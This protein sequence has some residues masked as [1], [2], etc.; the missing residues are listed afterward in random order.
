MPLIRK[1]AILELA[2]VAA[3]CLASAHASDLESPRALTGLQLQTL[4]SGNTVIGADKDGPFWMYYANDTTVWGRS[5]GGDV[6]I[7]RWWIENHSYCRSWRR[8]FNGETR[9]WQLSAVGEDILVW[10][11]L[12]GEPVGQST[13]RRG[14]AIGDLPDAGSQPGQLADAGSGLSSAL[15]ALVARAEVEPLGLGAPRG[16]LGD[17]SDQ[18]NTEPASSPTKPAR[19]GRVQDPGAPVPPVIT[20]ISSSADTQSSATGSAAGGGTRVG[21]FLDRLGVRSGGAAAEGG[22]GGSSGGGREAKGGTD[23]N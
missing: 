9:C 21:G 3:A 23:R 20:P 13:L 18:G 5:A 22:G 6:D 1:P 4:L 10:S 19:R 15:A 17:A 16:S 14:N 12:D 8:W 11:S 7:G 2:A